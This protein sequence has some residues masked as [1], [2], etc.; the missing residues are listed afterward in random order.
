[1]FEA[2][3]VEKSGSGQARL[4]RLDDDALPDGDVLVRVAW[5]TLNYKDALAVTGKGPILRSFPMVPGIDLVGV[6]EDSRDPAWKAGDR[7]LVNG[8]GIGESWWGGLAG[9]ARLKG[10][11]LLAPPSSLTARQTMAIGTAGYTAMLCVM[12]LERCGLSPDKG[13]V[14]VTGASGGVGGIAIALLARAGYRVIA[15]TGRLSEEAYLKSLGAAEVVDRA[16]FSAPGAPL[17]KA[18]FSG[19]IDSVGSHTL[20]NVCASL[21]E[22][23]VVAACGLAQGMDLPASVA[24]FILRGAS[25]IGIESVR[26]PMGVRVEAWSRL[27]RELDGQKLEAM[28][29]EIALCEAIP[30]SARVL[31][32]EVRGRLAVAVDPQAAG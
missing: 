4:A 2:V 9:K 25:L 17:Q 26:R 13:D 21:K 19:A 28:T 16:Q 14:L 22:D 18:R 7:V 23:G 3:L 15:S 27:A 12:A 29:Q 1:M 20:A 32:G 31:A 24:P 6:V 10:A 11:W 5:S 8:Y 30:A